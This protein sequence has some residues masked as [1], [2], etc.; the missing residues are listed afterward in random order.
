MKRAD[1][2][3]DQVNSRLQHRHAKLFNRL[4]TGA[5]NHDLWAEA[6][7]IVKTV[8]KGIISRKISSVATRQ[9]ANDLEVAGASIAI[10]REFL[11][12]C[13]VSDQSQ[14]QIRPTRWL[15]GQ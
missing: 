4:V 8:D 15:I 11:C 13:P 7:K 2:S 6:Q 12:N 5:F 3:Y 10:G 9:G 1:R 14:S